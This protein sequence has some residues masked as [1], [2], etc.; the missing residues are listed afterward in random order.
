MMVCR[1]CGADPVTQDVC[2]NRANELGAEGLWECAP[3]CGVA[4]TDENIVAAIIGEW[5][6]EL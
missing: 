4:V 6:E 2:L 3:S 5:D 1:K